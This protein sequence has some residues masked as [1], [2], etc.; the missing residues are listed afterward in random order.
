LGITIEEDRAVRQ[1]FVDAQRRG[2]LA[3]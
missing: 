3:W 1:I 2:R